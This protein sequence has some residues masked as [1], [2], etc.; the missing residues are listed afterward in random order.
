MSNSAD[1]INCVF[2]LVVQIAETLG[3]HKLS[4]RAHSPENYM[5]TV[6]RC[7]LIA[8]EHALVVHACCVCVCV[9]GGV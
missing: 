7:I 1:H 2:F 5:P 9:E 4:T 3:S 8:F 6:V